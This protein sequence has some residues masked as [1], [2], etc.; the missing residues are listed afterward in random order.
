MHPQVTSSTLNTADSCVQRRTNLSFPALVHISVGP[1]MVCVS[2]HHKA[3]F[4][5]QDYDICIRSF[6]DCSF[7]RKYVEDL[8]TEKG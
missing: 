3:P 1:R 7:P 2:T 6:Q 5:I 4:R 8:G